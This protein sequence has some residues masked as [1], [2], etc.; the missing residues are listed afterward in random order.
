MTV[1]TP[2]TTPRIV[3]LERSLFVRSASAAMPTF[4]QTWSTETK[5]IIRRAAR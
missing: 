4:S 5:R 3:R 1:A 2:I